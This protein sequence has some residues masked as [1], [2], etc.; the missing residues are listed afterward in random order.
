[1]LLAANGA[2]A[3]IILIVGLFYLVFLV[4]MIAAWVKILTKAGYSGWW[5]LIGLVPL[6]N[7]I[8]FFVFA[9]SDWPALRATRQYQAG[10]YQPS[11]YQR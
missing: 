11:P 6:V 1:M 7:M 9:F 5:I 2:A 10:P 4:L 3:G 8:M